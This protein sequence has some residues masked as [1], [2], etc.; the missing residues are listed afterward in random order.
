MWFVFALLSALFAG[1]QSFLNKVAAERTYDSYYISASSAIV[2]FLAALL[3]LLLTSSSLGNI[4]PFLYWLALA[5]GLFY[6]GRTITQLESLR[7]IDAAIFFPLYKVIGP[8]AVTVIG[9]FLLK[10][11]I[12]SLELVGIILSC[13]VPL[14]LITKAEDRRQKN[15]KLGLALMV[16]STML[17]AFT[18]V[19]NAL[20]VQPDVLL[21]VP[22]M[23]M[24]YACSAVIG[25]VIYLRRY[26]IKELYATVKGHSTRS[27]LILGTAI[28]LL[29]CI[30]FYFL[31]L[32]FSA[33]DL[34]VVYSINAHSIILPVILS[35][36][37]YKE[38][39]NAQKAFALVVSILALI[40]LHP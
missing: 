36:L 21:T 25:A 6:I 7:F 19:A 2:S 16:V 18:V 3:L 37:L 23:V 27:A 5:S 4:P 22:F 39:W 38:H 24:A 34:S 31:L 40:L 9:I 35:V 33:G 13:V 32:A 28:G 17:A 15:L 1:L 10:D 8:A 12:S 14:L 20:A 26:K 30:S 11:H 29:Q